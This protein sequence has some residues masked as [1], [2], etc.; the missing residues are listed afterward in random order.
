MQQEDLFCKMIKTLIKSS[1]LQVNNPYYMA[2]E[3]LMRDIIDNKQCLY[4]MVLPQELTTQILRAAHDA[5][6]YMA[7]PEP[8]CLSLN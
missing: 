6:G 2:D 3:L 7:L 4:N 5:L 1:K 8:T